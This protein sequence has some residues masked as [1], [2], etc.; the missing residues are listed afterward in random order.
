M[1]AG[2]RR[3]VARQGVLKVMW[4]RPS[5]E[6]LRLLSQISLRLCVSLSLSLSLSFP[7]TLMDPFV[8]PPIKIALVCL[9]R[10]AFSL[11][12]PFFT[13]NDTRHLREMAKCFC[14]R[15]LHTPLVLPCFEFPMNFLVWQE[16]SGCADCKNTIF[17][18]ILPLL[19]EIL[20]CQVLVWLAGF[21]L[22]LA[23]QTIAER[24]NWTYFLAPFI[25]KVQNNATRSF[26]T[27]EVAAQFL[28]KK[29]FHNL[30]L[31]Q[32]QPI[33]KV[34]LGTENKVIQVVCSFDVLCWLRG[35]I[36]INVL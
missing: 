12:T 20:R 9:S 24:N 16:C 32:I 14:F 7:Y 31:L 17:K 23:T 28:R 27:S 26:I 8:S 22:I 15:W 3:R 30:H 6:L 2:S 11:S 25:L 21:W 10:S 4:R 1:Q 33:P 36:T 13:L 29:Y 34:S 18:T 5:N 35:Q 19:S